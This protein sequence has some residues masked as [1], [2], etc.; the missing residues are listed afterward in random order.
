VES[1]ELGPF[2]KAP[3]SGM[4]TQEET[5]LPLKRTFL[6]FFREWIRG[7]HEFLREKRCTEIRLDISE[8]LR[9]FV[10]S[11]DTEFPSVNI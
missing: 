7:F 8:N 3:C 11:F 10:T 4:W 6:F 9:M 2:P 5:V 1:E